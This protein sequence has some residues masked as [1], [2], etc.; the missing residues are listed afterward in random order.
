MDEVR[1]LR[2]RRRFIQFIPRVSDPSMTHPCSCALLLRCDGILHVLDV[3]VDGLALAP[4][5]ERT[6]SRTSKHCRNRVRSTMSMRISNGL[7]HHVIESLAF[8]FGTCAASLRLQY[9]AFS[10]QRAPTHAPSCEISSTTSRHS[11]RSHGAPSSPDRQQYQA[12]QR[13]LQECTKRNSSIC[14]RGSH[15]Q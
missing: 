12:T 13:H 2:H 15:Q 14:T 8:V 4:F 6:A 9:V 5:A 11:F 1:I 3:T 7:A 10:T